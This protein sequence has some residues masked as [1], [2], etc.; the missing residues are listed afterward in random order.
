MRWWSKRRPE[1]FNLAFL[2]IMACGLGAIILIFM[3]VKYHS[4]QPGTELNALQMELADMQDE[5]KTIESD[6][7][8]L[9]A[10]IEQLK[11]AL[12]RQIKRSAQSD[13]ESGATAEEII[14][15]AKQIARLE[16]NKIRQQQQLDAGQKTPEATKQK[17]Q[18]EHLIGLRVAGSRILILLDNS[19]SMAAERLVDIVKIKA[20][21]TAAKQSA[22]KWRR[23]VSVARWIIER[24]PENSTYMVINYNEKADFLP[25]KKWL[26]GADASAQSTLSQALDELYPQAATNL[27][28]ALKLIKTSSIAPTDIYIIT[29]SL[30]TRG[31]GTLSAVKRI[32][33]CGV[34]TGKT[35]ISGKCRLALFYS[36]VRSFS[37]VAATVNTVL[38]PIEGDPEAAHAYWRWAVATKGVMISPAGSWP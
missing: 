33:G 28:S 26:S 21:N 8:T 27:H 14:S 12:Q 18:E 34:L 17:P 15:V 31:P 20:S 24:V 37:G 19:A 6:N 9:A 25:G 13:Q 36:A 5:I 16:Q 35:T 22:P 7:S 23:A 10:Q 30:P 3:L 2:D 1:G 32:K 11:Q 38:L 4:E 29:D